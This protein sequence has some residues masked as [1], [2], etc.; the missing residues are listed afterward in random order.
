MP[1]KDRCN[2]C[3]KIIKESFKVSV[4]R[5][6]GKAVSEKKFCSLKCANQYSTLHG[7]HAKHNLEQEIK[8]AVEEKKEVVE[9][10]QKIAEQ[11]EG[12]GEIKQETATYGKKKTSEDV[13]YGKKEFKDLYSLEKKPQTEYIENQEFYVKNEKDF[14][15][16]KDTIKEIKSQEPSMA[17]VDDSEFYEIEPETKKLK[18]RKMPRGVLDRL[19]EQKLFLSIIKCFN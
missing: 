13:R 18:L 14:D 11:Q 10:G 3:G 16:I 12:I 7:V 17:R 5:K 1:L 9:K 8:E 15:K 6:K 19:K 2:Q 4:T